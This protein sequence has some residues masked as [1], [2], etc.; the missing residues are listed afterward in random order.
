MLRY[1]L[2]QDNRRNAANPG[3]WYARPTISQT[4]GLDDLAEHM[5]AHDTPFSKGVIYGVLTDMVHPTP[6]ISTAIP[7]CRLSSQASRTSRCFCAVAIDEY[8]NHY[9]VPHSWCEEAFDVAMQRKDS[10]N[11]EMMD[12]HTYDIHPLHPNARFILFDACYNGSFYEKDNIAGAYIFAKGKTIATI[13]GTVNALQDKWPDEFVGLLAAGMR[14]GQ[15]NRLTG[16][17]ESHLIG[18]PTFRFSDNSQAGF[19]I[20][21]AL[22]LHHADAAFWQKKL[23]HPLPDVQAMALRQ[24]HYARV[25]SL[26]ALL[27]KTYFNSD[28]FVVRMEAV[29]LLGLYYPDQAT[30]V[31][32]AAFNDSY[33]LVR[34]L[35]SEM[36]ERNASP[37]FI[38]SIV[39]ATI[40]RGYENRLNFRLLGSLAAFD[41]AALTAE[42]DRQLQVPTGKS[43]PTTV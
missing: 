5:A 16:Y 27:E 13:G 7:T 21:Q 30:E 18:D 15:F 11:N 35:G 34:R 29:R 2:Y 22:A 4:Y 8:A 23:N 32:K 24:L 26:P 1:R 40:A 12:I 19:D 14:I 33:E 42:M 31:L 6:S 10:I 17:L 41:A 28:C 38:P 25:P 20:N 3:A 43:W 37:A 9:N 39:A 36:A